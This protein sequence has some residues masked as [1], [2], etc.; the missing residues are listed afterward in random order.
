MKGT[1]IFTCGEYFQA[2]REIYPSLPMP[3]AKK[4][5][6]RRLSTKNFL[7]FGVA[8]TPSSCYELSLMEPSERRAFLE[9]I[10]GKKGLGLRVARLCIG[11]CDY[12][13]ELYSYDDVADDREL[14]H[15]S[16]ARDEKYVI[17]MIKEM[18]LNENNE[19]G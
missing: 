11:S 14:K 12:S 8:I 10:Y 18:I 1:H 17:P 5:Q 2:E 6:R 19:K 3:A 15:F 4:L 16:V 7:G 9:K 13:P